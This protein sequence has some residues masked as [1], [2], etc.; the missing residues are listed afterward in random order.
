MVHR[1][2]NTAFHHVS[3]IVRR[4]R[5]RISYIKNDVGDWIQNETEV[6][7]F[8]RQGFDKLLTSSLDSAPPTPP[9]PSLWQTILTEEEKDTLSM[10]V[11]DAKIKGPFESL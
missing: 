7:E 1:D 4:R 3:T 9:Q 11:S 2:R 6:M 5:N 8:I 10:P